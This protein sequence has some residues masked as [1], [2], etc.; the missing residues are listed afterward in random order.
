MLKALVNRRIFS[1]RIDGRGDNGTVLEFGEFGTQKI[2]DLEHI[3]A[4]LALCGGKSTGIGRITSRAGDVD[5][6]AL[7]EKQGVEP[8][9]SKLGRIGAGE[10]ILVNHG[11]DRLLGIAA[12]V[13]DAIFQ[14]IGCW[15]WDVPCS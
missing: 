11:V 3:A 9:A 8:R 10:Q 4:Q 2:D 7:A 6:K 5:G 14:Q 15:W 13:V 1:R 12:V